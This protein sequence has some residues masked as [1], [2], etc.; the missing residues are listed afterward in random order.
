VSFAKII[1][2]TA[3][4]ARIGRTTPSHVLWRW[5]LRLHGKPSTSE[6][7]RR[8]SGLLAKG[9]K[10]RVL[11]SRPEHRLAHSHGYFLKG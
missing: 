9:S 6:L 1:R 4:A 2:V 5:I 10:P 7:S 11:V 3:R 8:R